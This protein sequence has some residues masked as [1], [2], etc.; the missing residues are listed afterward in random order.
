M[1]PLSSM[2]I[3]NINKAQ[4]GGTRLPKVSVII[5]T[6]NA[7]K[8]IAETI[9]SVLAQTYRD[10][11]VIV[12]DDGSTDN[13]AEIVRSFGNQVRYI[14]KKNGGPGSARNVGV[15][16]ANGEYLTFLDHDDLWLP[17]KLELQT[18]VLDSQ[19]EIQMV[20]AEA[21]LGVDEP[22]KTCFRFGKA[23][24]GRIFDKLFVGNFI[25][26]L[27]ALVRRECLEKLGPF[28]E[29]G[30]MLTT[31]D[32]HMWL[33][34][35]AQFPVYCIDKP[36]ARFRLHASNLSRNVERATMDT[37]ATLE[38]ISQKYPDLVAKFP[39]LKSQ[40]FAELHYRLAK[41]RFFRGDFQGLTKALTT[42]L[43]WYP[44]FWKSYCFLVA[45]GLVRVLRF[46]GGEKV[47]SWAMGSVLTKIFQVGSLW[48]LRGQ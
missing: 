31:D 6:Y 29:T 25:P 12:V 26:N 20:Y 15:K 47:T 45:I 3:N 46:F 24:S 34:L 18:Q 8:F 2:R 13:T 48:K 27:T 21:Y 41:L 30:R 33:R 10:S 22:T 9:K 4:E 32:Y 16:N 14:Y 17:E 42:S 35:S 23:Y 36:L 5:P 44:L 38:D 11:E 40:R 28:D 7:S 43:H 37:L 39:R 1:L 19:P